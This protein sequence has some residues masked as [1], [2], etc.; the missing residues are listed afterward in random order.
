[1]EKQGVRDRVIGELKKTCLIFAYLTLF[2]GSFSIYRRML[3]A[4]YRVSYFHYGYTILEALVLAKVIVFGSVLRIGERYRDRP[5]IVPTLYKTLCFA[6]L[7]L[8]F[9]ILEHLLTGWWHG[10]TAAATVQEV[11]EPGAWEILSQV[12][13]K[14]LALLP[15]FAVWEVGRV[16]GDGKLFALFFTR[17][18]ATQVGPDSVT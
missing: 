15:L 7:L 10:K 8:A 3:L 4:E 13:V 18:A 11:L 14:F 12:Q 2:L 5:L 17:R 16:L 1:V 9:S 6:I